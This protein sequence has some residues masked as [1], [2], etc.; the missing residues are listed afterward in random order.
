MGGGANLRLQH[1]LSPEMS[2]VRRRV[3]Y[4]GLLPRS[5]V[6]S[7]TGC[8]TTSMPDAG[9]GSPT[10]LWPGC[11]SGIQSD[12]R[13]G[14]Q[15]E[16]RSECPSDHLSNLQ[17]STM[18]KF[19]Y[20]CWSDVRYDVGYH[21]NTIKQTSP[22]HNRASDRHKRN[23][24]RSTRTQ[25]ST[26]ATQRQSDT[27]PVYDHVPGHSSGWGGFPPRSYASD[28]TGGC[29]PIIIYQYE[30]DTYQKGEF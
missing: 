30:S 15:S 7:C 14:H 2:N 3:G 24:A 12:V 8:A 25:S 29:H 19:R 13:P 16:V 21:L 26:R 5:S 17:P 27:D 11:R 10:R 18:T 6:A 9:R 1:G 23:Q 28:Y 4:G 22:K 20:G